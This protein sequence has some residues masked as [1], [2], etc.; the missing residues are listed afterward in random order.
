MLRIFFSSLHVPEGSKSLTF[1]ENRRIPTPIKFFIFYPKFSDG[2]T[3]LYRSHNRD[4][5]G[6]RDHDRVDRFRFMLSMSD[7]ENSNVESTKRSSR[8][9]KMIFSPTRMKM[10]TPGILSPNRK[11]NDDSSNSDHDKDDF[12]IRSDKSFRTQEILQ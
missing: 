3:G 2:E 11:S 12:N 6:R 8:K 1:S 5:R 7:Y 4:H 9:G 10:V